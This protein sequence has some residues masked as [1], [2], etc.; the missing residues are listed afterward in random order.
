[1][2]GA[3]YM[4]TAPIM[5]QVMQQAACDCPP[6]RVKLSSH[7]P[8]QCQPF[9]SAQRCSRLCP[10]AGRYLW[11]QPLSARTLCRMPHIACQA[12]ALSEHS[13]PCSSGVCHP[14]VELGAPSIHA[15]GV[16]RWV[17]RVYNGA[18]LWCTA[19]P[20]CRVPAQHMEPTKRARL[21]PLSW[22]SNVEGSR[23]KLQQLI[24]V[25]VLGATHQGVRAP[26]LIV[27][28]FLSWASSTQVSDCLTLSDTSLPCK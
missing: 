12:H 19:G 14:E 18:T 2:L 3:L 10:A 5:S 25:I 26:P 24:S 8:A 7:Q 17:L 20:C 16:S 9:S 22:P 28:R 13:V 27:S 23:L 11:V 21:V 6:F 15:W 4:C 1:M